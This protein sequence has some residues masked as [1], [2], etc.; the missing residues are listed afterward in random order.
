MRN[1]DPKKAAQVERLG[2]GFKSASGMSHSAITGMSTIE[3]VR[4]R[5]RARKLSRSLNLF[6]L[7][8]SHAEEISQGTWLL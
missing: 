7:R 4:L 8:R 5:S 2:M 1:V 6:D 3:Q